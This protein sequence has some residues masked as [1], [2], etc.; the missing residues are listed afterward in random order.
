MEASG[1][2]GTLVP[3]RLRSCT[4]QEIGRLCFESLVPASRKIHHMFGACVYYLTQVS[5]LLNI[6]ID[7]I[8]RDSGH[9][10]L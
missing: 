8:H 3:N 6:G 7:G 10:I 1:A 5:G 4:L 9:W 2:P